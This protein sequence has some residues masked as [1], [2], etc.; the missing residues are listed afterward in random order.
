MSMPSNESS[1]VAG[2]LKT[3]ATGVPAD[4]S[5]FTTHIDAL[6]AEINTLLN[7][8]MRDALDVIIRLGKDA[9][10]DLHEW[11]ATFAIS[12]IAVYMRQYAGKDQDAWS[13]IYRVTREILDEYRRKW[14]E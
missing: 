9:G 1:A 2:G 13:A 8:D 11:D 10:D 5:P 12:S 6:R 4:Q 14:D 3:P 7:L